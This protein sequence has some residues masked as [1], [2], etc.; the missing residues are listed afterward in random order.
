M[1]TENSKPRGLLITFEGTEGMGKSTLLRSL[2]SELECKEIP[3]LLT[4][5]PG[6][7]E[8]SEEIRNLILHR[9]MSAWTELFLYEAARAEHLTQVIIPAL[10]KSQLVLCDRFADSTLAYQGHARGLNWSQI[11]TLNRI[12]TQGFKPDMTVL[13]DGDPASGLKKALDPNRFENEGVLFQ[14]KVR[15]GFLKARRES[16]KRWLT[17]KAYSAPP[18]ALAQKVIAALEKRFRTRFRQLTQGRPQ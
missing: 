14:K 16:P 13:L 4:R 8:V 3:F 11:K 9:E 17:L 6:G 18:E 2:A 7:P 15:E 5:E 12:A 1:G 10:M